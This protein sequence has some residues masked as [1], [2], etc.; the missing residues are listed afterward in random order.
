MT[1]K[2]NVDINQANKA[3]QF[4]ESIFWL[5]SVFVL[6]QGIYVRFVIYTS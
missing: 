4:L 1:R 6:D 2:I 3:M 5:G